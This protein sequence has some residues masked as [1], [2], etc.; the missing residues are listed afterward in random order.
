MTYGE[1]EEFASE[2]HFDEN[3]LANKSKKK[4]KEIDLSQKVISLDAFRKNN[5]PNSDLNS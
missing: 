2:N 5:K 3:N 4:V 1:V